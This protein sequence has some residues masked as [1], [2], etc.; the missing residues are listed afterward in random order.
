MKIKNNTAAWPMLIALLLIASSWT[1]CVQPD[2]CIRSMESPSTEGNCEDGLTGPVCVRQLPSAVIS[3]I[4]GEDFATGSIRIDAE[5]CPNADCD[6]HVN[7][8]KSVFIQVFFEAPLPNGE[9]HVA[10][11]LNCNNRTHLQAYS[12]VREIQIGTPPGL[13]GECSNNTFQNAFAKWE[14]CEVGL[15]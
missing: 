1:G 9:D 15:P 7:I 6:S 5:W 4:V 12:N 13:L 3:Y 8:G 11:D 2:T 14:I 10:I